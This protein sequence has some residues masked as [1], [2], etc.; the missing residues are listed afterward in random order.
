MP[1]RIPPGLPLG[2]PVGIAPWIHLG[3]SS[4]SLSGIAP[5]IPLRLSSKVR[6]GIPSGISQVFIIFSGVYPR[7]SIGLPDD[8][9]ELFQEFFQRTEW[10]DKLITTHTGIRNFL[11]SLQ[12]SS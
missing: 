12:K 10:E 9:F 1:S 11:V 6:L 4:G 3:D 5:G 7:I 2:I 8:L